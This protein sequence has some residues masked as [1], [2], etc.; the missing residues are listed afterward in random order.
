M[1]PEKP[2][3]LR[4]AAPGKKLGRKPFEPTQQ[5]FEHVEALAAMGASDESISEFMGID[6]ETLR[7]YFSSTLKTGKERVK[8]KLRIM[9]LKKAYSGHT[10]MLIWLGKNMLGQADKKAIVVDEVDGIEF[11]YQDE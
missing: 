7:K 11:E 10:G 5:N 2:K 4:K 8:N 1:L 9:Q 6:D 3:K